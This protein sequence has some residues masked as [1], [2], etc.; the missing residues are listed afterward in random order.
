MV[1]TKKKTKKK[2]KTHAV[3]SKHLYS[4][5]KHENNSFHL[6]SNNVLDN[7]YDGAVSLVILWWIV[8]NR[9]IHT[10][11]QFKNGRWS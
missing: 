4:I 5:M 11:T 6:E 8:T 7:Q 1:V 10:T 9:S 2:K 3:T